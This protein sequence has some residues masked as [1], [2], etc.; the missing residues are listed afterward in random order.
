MGGSRMKKNKVAS[1]LMTSAS[2]VELILLTPM[3]P[4]MNPTIIDPALS[5]RKYHL[6]DLM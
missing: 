1:N 5:G 4:R 6:L 2:S 3:P